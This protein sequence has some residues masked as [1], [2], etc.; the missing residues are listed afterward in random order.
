[1]CMARTGGNTQ[2]KLLEV[3][4]R[5]FS[6]HGF[7]GV[8]TRD[9]ARAAGTTLPSIPHHFGS[10]EGLYRAVLEDIAKQIIEKLS[11]ASMVAYEVIAQKQLTREQRIEALQN[12]LSSHTRAILQS[13]TDW[14]ALMGQGERLHSGAFTTIVQILD[15]HL[16]RPLTQLIA[17]IRGLPASG[18]EVK[19]E[20]IMLLGQVMIFRTHRAPSLRILKWPEVTP[21]RIEVIVA[22]MRHHVRETFADHA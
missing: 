15:K 22:L 2:M 18:T 6:E 3:S 11:A 8:S 9:I 17:V 4:T 16:V 13:P 10:K 1:M 5:L 12:L 21:A 19:L 14:S 7:D 20:A